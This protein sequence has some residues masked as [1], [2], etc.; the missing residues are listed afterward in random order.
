M[1]S[2]TSPYSSEAS[3][4]ESSEVSEV[5][6]VSEEGFVALASKRIP[7]QRHLSVYATAPGLNPTT[8][9]PTSLHFHRLPNSPNSLAKKLFTNLICA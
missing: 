2:S 6:E 9:R 3:E 5:S 8:A 1:A 4:L 7:R